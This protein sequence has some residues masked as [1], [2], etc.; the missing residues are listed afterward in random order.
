MSWRRSWWMSC[1]AYEATSVSLTL[2][3]LVCLADSAALNAMKCSH[4]I[5]LLVSLLNGFGEIEQGQESQ[6]QE[7]CSGDGYLTT[8]VRLQGFVAARRDVARCCL[9]ITSCLGIRGSLWQGLQLAQWPR[10]HGCTS[11]GALVAWFEGLWTKLR[12]MRQRALYWTAPPCATWIWLSRGST[13]R[14]RTRP[15]GGLSKVRIYMRHSG[16]RLEILQGHL[17][18]ESGHSPHAVLAPWFHQMCC[19][20]MLQVPICHEQGGLLCYREPH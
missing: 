2:S 13:G 5:P 9:H 3:C 7:E 19:A 4:L 12:S 20:R 16:A 11:G 10:V 8:G 17:Q 1:G 18:G 15:R 14:T 6:F